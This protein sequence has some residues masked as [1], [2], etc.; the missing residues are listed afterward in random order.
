MIAIPSGYNLSAIAIANTPEELGIITAQESSFTQPVRVVVEVP[1]DPSE[2]IA[3]VAQQVQDACVQNYVESWPEYPSTYTYIEN[4]TLY[5]MYVSPAGGVTPS[6]AWL[7]IIIGI[8]II[9]P[10]IMLIA[11]PGLMDL[12]N[13]IIMLVIIMVMMDI[14]T[15]MLRSS[16]APSSRVA[17]AES[18]QP[19][20]QRISRRIESIAE[21]IAR[22]ERAFETSKEAGKSAVSSVV[23]DIM[24]VARAIKGAPS[25]AMTSYEKARAAERIDVLDD[26]LV[27][28]RESLSPEQKAKLDE[29][30]RI[31]REL[32]ST[33]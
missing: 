17:A 30:Q 31:I 24:G 19:I 25:T 32:R 27:K 33:L 28:Y 11:I 26:K 1:L 22:T 20:E 7:P 29:E 15:P 14:M 6:I 12:I 3:S 8:L 5:I 16:T 9:A 13:N 18:R 10:I 2:D 21:S 4:N 23:S